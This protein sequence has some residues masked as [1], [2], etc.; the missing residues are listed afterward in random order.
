MRR[1]DNLPPFEEIDPYSIRAKCSNWEETYLKIHYS[2]SERTVDASDLL[3]F[4]YPA[5]IRISHRHSIQHLDSIFSEKNALTNPVST[6]KTLATLPDAINLH[7]LSYLKVPELETAS[8]I[9]SLY[10]RL[11]VDDFLWKPMAVD[12]I[13]MLDIDDPQLLRVFCSNWKET[14]KLSI[15]IFC[16]LIKQKISQLQHRPYGFSFQTSSF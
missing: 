10:K 5:P 14:H 7:I 15:K 16:A 6:A 1:N 8:K 13:Y 2:I 12:S 9:N 11:S 4:E 3:L